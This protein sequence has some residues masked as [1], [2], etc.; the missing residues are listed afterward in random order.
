M[1]NVIAH[2]VILSVV[3]HQHPGLVEIEST[4]LGVNVAVVGYYI[5]H[6][7]YKHMVSTQL[8]HFAHLAFN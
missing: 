3:I 1:A 4:G 2:L 8:E 6:V 5:Y 7:G